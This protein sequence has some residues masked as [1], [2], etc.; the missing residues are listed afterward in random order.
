MKGPGVE[1]PLVAAPTLKLPGLSRVKPTPYIASPMLIR[2]LEAPS[3]TQYQAAHSY[4]NNV[5]KYGITFHPV[6]HLPT[7]LGCF[8]KIIKSESEEL[9][10]G[11]S[12]PVERL[13]SQVICKKSTIFY[14]RN[15]NTTVTC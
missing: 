9:D 5:G 3:C 11:V 13:W 6:R 10:Q 2:D 15:W 8:R 1:Y 12:T 14:S 4:K 7:T